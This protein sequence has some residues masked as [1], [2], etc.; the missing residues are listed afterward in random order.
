MM[1][2]RKRRLNASRDEVARAF[3]ASGATIVANFPRRLFV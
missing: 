2:V 3:Q 1:S